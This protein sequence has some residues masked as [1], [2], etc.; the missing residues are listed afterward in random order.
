MFNVSRSYLVKSICLAR[1]QIQNRKEPSRE[2]WMA[3]IS[4][5]FF[6][7]QKSLKYFFLSGTQIKKSRHK[8][9][10][11]SKQMHKQMAVLYRDLVYYIK[12]LYKKK[13]YQMK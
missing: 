13:C 9:I 8:T 5:K 2:V 12:H 4:N 7:Y 3:P 10:V 11:L 1:I 6:E